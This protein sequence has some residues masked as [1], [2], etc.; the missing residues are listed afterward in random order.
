[1]IEMLPGAETRTGSI[2]PW[3]AKFFEKRN[4]YL[5][6]LRKQ[7]YHQFQEGFLD[8]GSSFSDMT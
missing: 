5:Q 6:M 1:M 7:R 8:P 4:R 2:I 3:R